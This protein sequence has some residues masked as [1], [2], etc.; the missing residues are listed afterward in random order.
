MSARGPL[1]PLI[2]YVLS[3]YSVAEFRRFLN[4]EIDGGDE[5]VATMDGESNSPIVVIQDLVLALK[6]EGG[7]NSGFWRTLKESRPGRTGDIEAVM[8]LSGREQRSHL[9]DYLVSAYD[10]DEVRRFVRYELERASLMEELESRTP[11]T[12]AVE[13]LH[14][15][16]LLSQAFFKALA[17]DREARPEPRFLAKMWGGYIRPDLAE[18]KEAV[19]ALSRE[20][21]TGQL[22][23]ITNVL[24]KFNDPVQFRQDLESRE[25]RVARI[26]LAG[27]GVG[28]GWLVGSNLLLTARHVLPVDG[29]LD[30]CTVL[31]DYKRVPR[32]EGLLEQR[33]R[34]VDIAS[35]GLLA[36]SWAAGEEAELQPEGPEDATLLDFAL[37]R[38]A[39]DVGEDII[40]T[41]NERGHFELPRREHAF[42]K[43][44]GLF[45]LG[46]PQLDGSDAGP[47]KL[48]MGLPSGAQRLSRGGRVRYTMNTQG[49]NSGSPVMDQDFHPV[50]LHHAG[51]SDQPEWDTQGLWP[52]GFNQGIPLDRIVASL[53]DQLERSVLEELGLAS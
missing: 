9:V 20:P 46:H 30:D 16:G 7:F 18:L 38:L 35:G 24:A 15:R 48:T 23:R 42:A 28:T 49:G 43:M 10:V 1:L 21:L 3:A 14:S 40:G 8:R 29:R 44:E 32:P 34:R 50:A 5:I 39:E 6:R 36:E 22:E 27:R 4:L 2:D 31:L 51:A 13:K 41:G 37:L 19:E 25:A 53:R 26:D 33:G 11:V 17:E 12:Q 47:L 52:G 45:V